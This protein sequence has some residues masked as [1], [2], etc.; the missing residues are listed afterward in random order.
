M[1]ANGGDRCAQLLWRHSELLR[2]VAHFVVLIHVN[3]QTALL[4]NLVVCHGNVRSGV[5][6]GLTAYG[7]GLPDENQ[8]PPG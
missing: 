5:D 6:R 4:A 7:Y 1:C 3:A 8:S 2:P